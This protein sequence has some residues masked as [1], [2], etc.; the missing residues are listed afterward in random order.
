MTR[1]AL[2]MKSSARGREQTDTIAPEPRAE[3]D[4]AGVEQVQ[5]DAPCLALHERNELHDT[6]AGQPA[7]QQLFHGIRCPPIAQRHHQLVD[8]KLPA[9]RPQSMRSLVDGFAQR[10]GLL[11]VV[12]HQ[13]YQ[14]VS[15][16][17]TAT[18][19]AR[20]GGHL[21]AVAIDKHALFHALDIGDASREHTDDHSS[22]CRNHRSY[23]QH[24]TSD[25]DGRIEVEQ[26]GGN[27]DCRRHR[28][29]DAQAKSEYA[30]TLPRRVQPQR[31]E[32]DQTDPA[33]QQHVQQRGAVLELLPTPSRPKRS[34]P[35]K[36][37]EPTKAAVQQAQG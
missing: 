29:D 25:L 20:E 21:R 34:S 23:S 17:I 3:D 28:N 12:M 7:L 14:V 19:H 11:A 35:A 24:S 6:N 30:G 18:T 5:L 8:I 10:I 31:H 36:Y 15:R 1:T 27:R 9:E 16:S 33:E 32:A 26:R 13:P 37:I 2:A 22:N 4:P